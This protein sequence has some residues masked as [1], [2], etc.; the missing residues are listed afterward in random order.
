MHV[1]A[2]E[3]KEAIASPSADSDLSMNFASDLSPS[4][5]VL[6]KRSLPAWS[7]NHMWV[8]LLCPVSKCSL[9]MVTLFL[10]LFRVVIKKDPNFSISTS[11][12]LAPNVFLEQ[13]SFSSLTS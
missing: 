1:G 10:C 4:N 5:S 2:L 9:M 13:M 12:V 11:K 7:T 3:V 8:L 6:G